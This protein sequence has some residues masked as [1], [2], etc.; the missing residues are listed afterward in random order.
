MQF[1][2][3]FLLTLNMAIFLAVVGMLN[4]TNYRS[5]LKQGSEIL[6]KPWR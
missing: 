4:K 3:L 1:K 2:A 6:A 5:G